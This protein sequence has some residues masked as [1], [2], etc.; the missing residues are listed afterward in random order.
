MKYTPPP[1]ILARLDEASVEQA[2]RAFYVTRADSSLRPE[3]VKKIPQLAGILPALAR[4]GPDPKLVD[5]AAG[6]APVGLMAARLLGWSN[7]T[8]IER[9][10][11]RADQASVG[12]GLTVAR[13]L[14]EAHGNTSAC[15]ACCATTRGARTTV[16]CLSRA[17]D[18]TR[19][20]ASDG[21]RCTGVQRDCRG[22]CS[23]Q[24][25]SDGTY[26]SR[27]DLETGRLEATVC[28]AGRYCLCQVAIVPVVVWD[29][30]GAR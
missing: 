17:V 29:M 20:G 21:D 15:V 2:L 19:G 25:N 1:E 13:R 6:R 27:Y 3:E 8:V 30:G 18:S 12:L 26:E 9:E 5:A 7:V 24:P 14:A 10:P 22:C 4:T 16:A 28:F 11:E 23:L